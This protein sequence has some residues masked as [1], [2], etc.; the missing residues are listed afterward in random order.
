MTV[1]LYHGDG[2][3]S[4]RVRWVLEELGIAYTLHR[5]P[6]PPRLKQPEYLSINPLGSLPFLIDGEVQLSESMAMCEYLVARHGPSPLT[7]GPDD[8]GFAAYRQ[9]CWFGEATLMPPVG[10]LVRYLMMT[11]AADR[12]AGVVEAA[13][14]SFAQ[15]LKAVSR[16][17][18]DR[19]YLVADRLTLA[20]VSVGYVL[21][22]AALLGESDDFPAAITAYLARLRGRDAYR[23]AAEREGQR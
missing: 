6:F 18:E 22:L 12:P 8:F 10:T 13:R 7:V 19:E 5:L 17:L 9:F 11:A 21:G 15:R 16:G 3:R 2:T 14:D 20:D 1:E 23:R 4:L